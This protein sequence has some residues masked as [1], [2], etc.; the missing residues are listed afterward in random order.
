MLSFLTRVP[1][2]QR[3]TLLLL[4]REEVEEAVVGPLVKRIQTCGAAA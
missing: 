2:P 1:V 4:V 3:N